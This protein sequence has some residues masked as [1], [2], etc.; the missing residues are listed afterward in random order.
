MI[1]VSSHYAVNL[2]QN[3]LL[4]ALY[5]AMQTYADIPLA[6]H[7]LLAMCWYLKKRG[8]ADSG[9]KYFLSSGH[10]HATPPNITG[11]WIPIQT[12]IEHQDLN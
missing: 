11:T 5:S 1:S 6:C 4:N 2:L 12:G 10:A 3:Q 9:A 7:C 8:K